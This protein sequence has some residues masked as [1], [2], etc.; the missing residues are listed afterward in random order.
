MAVTRRG[1]VV[2]LSD[3]Y[4]DTVFDVE[5]ATSPYGSDPYRVKAASE[6]DA[7]DMVLK[8][9]LSRNRP[10]PFQ[11]EDLWENIY[12]DDSWMD[13]CTYVDLGYWISDSDYIIRPAG[14]IPGPKGSASPRSE[15]ERL[16][17]DIVELVYD[18]DPYEFRDQYGS[19]E[20]FFDENMALLSTDRGVRELADWFDGVEIDFDSR[21]E[22]R[23]RDVLRRLRSMASKGR[24]SSASRK[25][26]TESHSRA[27]AKRKTHPSP[28]DNKKRFVKQHRRSRRLW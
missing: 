22:T 23:R 9:K 7:L 24:A 4:S 11:T 18:F 3:G 17:W 13:S 10:Y 19:K 14:R 2:Y 25:A 1:D 26:G 28:R 20:E 27:S 5:I 15:T 16:A 6:T 12:G 8:Y 21:L